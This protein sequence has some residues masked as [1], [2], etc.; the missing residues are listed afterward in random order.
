MKRPIWHLAAAAILGAIIGSMSMASYLYLFQLKVEDNT[1]QIQKL[2]ERT[3]KLEKK[4]APKIS[5]PTYTPPKR[6]W[7]ELW[8]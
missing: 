1:A 7:W 8:R 4:P 3:K 5:K 2:E 6:P